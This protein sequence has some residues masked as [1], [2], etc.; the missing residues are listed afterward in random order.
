MKTRSE[1]F[2]TLPAPYRLQ[3]FRNYY[4]AV[5]GHTEYDKSFPHLY[6]C[7][8][9]SFIFS[10]TPQGQNYWWDLIMQ[11]CDNWALKKPEVQLNHIFKA[12]IDKEN[13]EIEVNGYQIFTFDKVKELY[14]ACFK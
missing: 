14:D 6:D 13:Q 9:S 3:C 2:N 10:E 7:I 11:Y 12:T 8:S 4:V 1:W 5:E